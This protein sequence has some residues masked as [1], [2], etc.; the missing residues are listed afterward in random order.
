MKNKNKIFN[1]FFVLNLVILISTIY[2]LYSKTIGSKG[3][4]WGHWSYSELLINYPGQFVRRGLLG[5]IILTLVSGDSANSIIQNIVFYNFSLFIF[6]ITLNIFRT[7]LGNWHLFFLT[8]SSFGVFNLAIHN[9]VFHRKEIFFLN[10]FLIYFGLINKVKGQN[11]FKYIFL[12]FTIIFTGLIHEGMLLIFGPFYFYNL[13]RT[14]IKRFLNIKIENLYLGLSIALFSLMALFKGD[15]NLS[16]RILNELPINDITLL[17]VHDTHAIDA[18]GWSI[19]RGL[20]LTAR[21][22]LSGT[23]FY[24]TYVIALFFIS[25]CFI[26]FKGDLKT[27]ITYLKDNFSNSYEFLLLILIFL[28]GWDW[29]RWFVII[30]YLTFFTISYNLNI[31][32]NIIENRI[33]LL[34]IFIF[35]SISILSVIPECCLSWSNP[36][37]LEVFELYFFEIKFNY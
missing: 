5:E 1:I 10:L 24:W 27:T 8:I 15:K 32:G 25:I 26:L 6:L 3:L 2:V 37:I 9:N 18:I 14:E 20:A 22:F 13:K 23:A 35:V 12:F 33:N 29:G 4:D 34:S 21:L 30:F 7:G 36:K 17:S 28:V 31:K 19:K 11:V 16:E